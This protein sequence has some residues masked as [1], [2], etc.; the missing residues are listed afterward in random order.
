[1]VKPVSELEDDPEAA[2]LETTLVLDAEPVLDDT[3]VVEVVHEADTMVTPDP[4]AQVEN[5]LAH[6]SLQVVELQDDTET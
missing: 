1:M 2:V 4:L 6:S 5:A 3:F